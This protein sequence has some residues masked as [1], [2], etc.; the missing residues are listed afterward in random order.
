MLFLKGKG[1]FQSLKILTNTSRKN[2]EVPKLE[3][4]PEKQQPSRRYKS[5]SKASKH[6]PGVRIFTPQT[7]T[8]TLDLTAGNA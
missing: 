6:K 5:T 7:G 2:P 3:V 1:E 8:T 4:K